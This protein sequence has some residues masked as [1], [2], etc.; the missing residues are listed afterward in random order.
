VPGS[1]ILTCL[2][3]HLRDVE[4]LVR[5]DTHRDQRSASWAQTETAAKARFRALI[6]MR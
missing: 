1:E 3:D 4:T 6:G 2:V 5:V